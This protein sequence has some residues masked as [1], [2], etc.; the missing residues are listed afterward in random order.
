MATRTSVVLVVVL[1]LLP[2]AT[3]R[4]NVQDLS[5]IFTSLGL[6]Q[7]WN[8]LA[9]YGGFIS[10]SPQR[11]IG[12]G[13]CAI[14]RGVIIG[15]LGPVPT[16]PLCGVAHMFLVADWTAFVIFIGGIGTI[17]GPILGA[18][19]FFLPQLLLADFGT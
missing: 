16:I 12:I 14:F 11:F 1:A 13:A 17:E 18:L 6:A 5:F 19:I 4:G 15:G 3:G 2:L 9:E 8:Q 7:F 10:L